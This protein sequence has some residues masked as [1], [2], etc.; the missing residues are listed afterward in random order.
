MMVW[1]LL[2]LV[3]FFLLLWL[4]NRQ[5]AGIAAGVY[6]LGDWVMNL[7]GFFMQGIVIPLAGYCLASVVFPQ[8]LPDYAGTLAIGAGGALLL[9]L[10]GVDLLYYL[11]HR[12]FHQLPWLWKLH[13]PHHYSPTLNIWAT[14]RNAL[15]THFLFVYLLIN[16]VLGYLCDVPE[17]F[18]AGAMLTAALDLLRHSSMRAEWSL[19]QGI[20]VLPRDHHRHHD[21]NKQFAN[22]GANFIIWDRMFNTAD[23]HADYPESYVVAGAPDIRTQL[24]CPWRG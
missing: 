20:L 24:L 6:S 3:T 4:Q 13:A 14:A 23:L 11:Q 1:A 18:F 2:P 21:G 7:S 22:F 5:P 12:A 10:L 17:A 16:P 8:I 15:L 9:N 19:L